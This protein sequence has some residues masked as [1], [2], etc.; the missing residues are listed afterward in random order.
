MPALSPYNIKKFY[1]ILDNHNSYTE[2]K[3]ESDVYSC[4]VGNVHT[5]MNNLFYYCKKYIEGM[6]NQKWLSKW[7][8]L[9][10]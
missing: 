1:F 8:Y 6:H 10:I 7:I 5:F 3:P 2:L 9:H 4:L